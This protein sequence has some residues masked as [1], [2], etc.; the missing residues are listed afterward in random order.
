MK[1]V[2]AAI[3]VLLSAS[4]FSPATAQVPN[5]QFQQPLN[6]RFSVLPKSHVFFYNRHRHRHGWRH[7]HHR[8][9]LPVLAG[10]AVIYQNG[11]VG[12]PPAYTGSVP[13]VPTVATP[14]VYRLGQNGGCDRQQVNV[15]GSHG[16]TAVNIWRC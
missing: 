5:R 13:A 9:F 8:Q 4:A 3:L 7:R 11:D 16:R 6:Y 10:P 12:I 15:P 14:V 2:A 1:R